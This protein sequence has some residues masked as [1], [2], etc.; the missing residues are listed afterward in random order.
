MDA[1]TAAKA[2]VQYAACLRALGQA[3]MQIQNGAHE[4]QSF[5][6]RVQTLLVDRMKIHENAVAA[7]VPSRSFAWVV[8]GGPGD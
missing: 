4:N 3:E 6:F 8:K 5:W 1:E 7:V 2:L